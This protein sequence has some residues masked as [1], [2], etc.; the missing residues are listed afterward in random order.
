MPDKNDIKP[1]ELREILE[2]ATIVPEQNVPR[3][4]PKIYFTDDLIAIYTAF[5]DQVY[6]PQSVLYPSSGFDASPAKVFRNVTFVD[7][8]EGNESCVAKLQ[9]AGLQALK[10]DIRQYKPTQEH[11][12]LILLNPSIPTEWASRHLKSGGYVI[13]NNYHGNASEMY[14]SPDRFTLWGVIN[15]LEQD[16]QKGVNQAVVSRDITDLFVP[17]ENGEE[18]KRRRPDHYEFISTSYPHILRTMSIKPAERFEDM[19]VQFQ[20][21]MGESEQLPSKRVADRYIFVKK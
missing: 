2:S 13:A 19:Y 10:Q 21:L 20:R 4:E 7:K 16:K 3:E 15:S 6:N 17:V 5:R 11:D 18:L 1:G 9:E 14:K 8:E 12:L